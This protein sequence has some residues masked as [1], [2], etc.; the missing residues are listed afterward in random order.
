MESNI[1]YLSFGNGKET[2][3][4]EKE[5][6]QHTPTVAEDEKDENEHKKGGLEGSGSSFHLQRE[7]RS[8]IDLYKRSQV[9]ALLGIPEGRLKWWEKCGLVKPSRKFGK[10]KF[11]T[12]QNL[13][14][15]RAAK[16]LTE[17]GCRASLIKKAI[18]KLSED[19]EYAEKPLTKMKVYGNSRRLVVESE[20][21]EVE[22]D[23]GQVLIE[24]KVSSLVESIR[25]GAFRTPKDKEKETPQ[26]SSLE[27]FLKGIKLE[28]E[29]GEEGLIKA[30]EA[31]R[32][33]LEIEPDMAP[34]LTNLGNLKFKSGDFV[35]AENFYREA[36]KIDPYLPQ[37][38]YNLG[39]LKLETGRP[40]LAIIFLKKAHELDPSFADACFNL[41]LAYEK[42]GR[43]EDAVF[44]YRKFVEMEQDSPWSQMAREKID[45]LR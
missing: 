31:Y 6:F 4:P 21:K 23:S 18:Q 45:L 43:K 12:F 44:Y 8:L 42:E 13:I 9:S 30:E 24:F 28:D 14:A 26:L 25:T 2:Q 10:E 7:H 27:W 39:C 36:I 33:A 16:E 35:Q 5:D 19:L 41:A 3:N 1:I 20:G 32:K 29:G 17:R 15:A 38:Y 37:P 34:A 40:D 11:Y 22:V